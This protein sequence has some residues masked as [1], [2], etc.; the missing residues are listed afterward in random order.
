M[1]TRVKLKRTRVHRAKTKV[2]GL[3]QNECTTSDDDVIAMPE[4]ED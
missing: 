3:G 2:D 4:C 1:T